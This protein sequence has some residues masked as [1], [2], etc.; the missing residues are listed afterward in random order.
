MAVKTQE[1]IL[2]LNLK[3]AIDNPLN[4]LAK[5]QRLVEVYRKVKKI[6]YSRQIQ[7]EFEQAK[8]MTK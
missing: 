8:M 7:R 1:E 4:S 6:G 5:H 3:A 2:L